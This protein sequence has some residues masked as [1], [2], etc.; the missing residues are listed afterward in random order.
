[1]DWDKRVGECS[2]GRT[3]AGHYGTK[4]ILY[5]VGAPGKCPKFQPVTRYSKIASGIV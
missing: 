3:V 4:L 2:Q 1:V 5:P